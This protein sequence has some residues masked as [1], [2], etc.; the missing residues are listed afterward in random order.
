MSDMQ[1]MSNQSGFTLLELLVALTIITVGLFAVWSLF[2]ANYNSEKEAR[3]RVIA[4]NLAREGIEVVRNIRD[5]NW[6]KINENVY[7]NVSTPYQWYDGLLAAGDATS[8]IRDLDGEAYLYFD[9]VH[10]DDPSSDLKLND[11]GFYVNQADA[12]GGKNTP[13][14]RI[15]MTKSICCDD[16]NIVDN[17]CDKDAQGRFKPFTGSNVGGV[18]PLCNP[19]N[20]LTIGIDVSVAIRWQIDGQD[21]NLVVKDQLFNWR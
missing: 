14:R 10:I 15:I 8:V 3:S 2:L 17:Q 13:Y 4:V 11:D 16:V 6:M 7:Q 12:S 21:R 5:S 20:Q 19:D 18:F 9:A 1:K